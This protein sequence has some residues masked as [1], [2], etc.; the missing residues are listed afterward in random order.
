MKINSNFFSGL[1]ILLSSIAVSIS[2]LNPIPGPKGETGSQGSSGEQGETPFIGENGNWWIGDEDTGIKATI[3]TDASNPFDNFNLGR[4]EEES[5]LTR[6]SSYLTNDPID[7][8]L[9]SNYVTNLVDDGYTLISNATQLMSISNQ[10]GDYVLGND[11]DLSL[12]VNWQPITFDNG[13]FSGTLDGAGFTLSGLST[14]NINPDNIALHQ[15]GLFNRIEDAVIRNLTIEDFYFDSNVDLVGALAGEVVTSEITYVQILDSYIEGYQFVGGLFGYATDIIG[16]N[17]DANNNVV[18]G[19]DLVGGLIGFAGGSHFINLSSGL[20]QQIK[21]HGS[22]GGG[23]IGELIDGTLLSSYSYGRVSFSG[24][25]VVSNYYLGGM[26]GYGSDLIIMSVN[27]YASVFSPLDTLSTYVEY[28][29]GIAGYLNRSRMS[30]PINYGAIEVFYSGEGFYEILSLGG[31]VGEMQNSSIFSGFNMGTVRAVLADFNDEFVIPVSHSEYIAGLVG[32]QRESGLIVG[33]LNAGP[34][35]GGEE[36]GGLVG[37]TGISISQVWSTMVINQ[38]INMGSIR[39]VVKV[40]GLLGSIDAFFNA[41]ITQSYN[42]GQVEGDYGVGGI[43]GFMMTYNGLP[44]LIKEVYNTGDVIGISDLGGIVGATVRNLDNPEYGTGFLTIEQSFQVGTIVPLELGFL[45][46][47]YDTYAAGSIAG[48]NVM[49]GR[50]QS[51]SYLLQEGEVNLYEFDFVTEETSSFGSQ[52]MTLPA[53]SYGF[54]SQTYAFNNTNVF[55]KDQFVYQSLWNM[56]DVWEFEDANSYP[57]LKRNIINS[58]S[59]Q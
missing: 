52:W 30:N 34:V 31:L 47:D 33:S 9:Q 27:N 39:G 57:N 12:L 22:V 5:L 53:V 4:A 48:V 46:N 59:F 37:G 14:E 29:G 38:S 16:D 17:L 35:Y 32:Y 13:G 7:L 28:L 8:S 1:A 6:F 26:I 54:Q 36:V 55:K 25:V 40:G 56:K 24:E 20:L 45:G 51:T 15:L 42:R 11:I 3:E 21:V 58:L 44:S 19:N 2:L 18:I 41:E 23:L 10:S 50:I 43:I 49:G